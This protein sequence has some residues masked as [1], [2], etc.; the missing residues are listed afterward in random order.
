MAPGAVASAGPRHRV[1]LADDHV[2]VLDMLRS[3]LEREF[4][5]VGAASDGGMLLRLARELTPDIILVD[6][7]MPVLG[8]LEAGKALRS[9]GSRAKLV[10]LTMETDPAIAAEAFAV[11]ASAYLS[12]ASP[13][14]ELQSVLRLVATGGRYLTSVIADGDI[15]ALCARHS[16]NPVARLSPRELEV[17]KLLV[18]GM[19]MKAVARQLGIAPRT[20]AF[21]KYRAMETLGLH[22][23]SDL[24]DFAIRHGLLPGRASRLITDDNQCTP[25][26]SPRAP[27]E[28][29][30]AALR[31][32]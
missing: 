27:Y 31:Q 22:G 8:G 3:L 18:S 11:G 28:E 4:E 25:A 20:I 32:G 14:A 23:N 1:L 30:T 29:R 12:K 17:L 13:V 21:H 5:V 16:T 19:S 9:H 2:L 7:V 26:Y 6:V 15:E 24:V 10:Y